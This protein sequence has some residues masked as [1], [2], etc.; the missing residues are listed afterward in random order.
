MK[1]LRRGW[2]QLPTSSRECLSDGV[3]CRQLASV[4]RF[5]S[6]QA[7]QSRPPGGCASSKVELGSKWG[8]GSALPW[9]ANGH[10]AANILSYSKNWAQPASGEHHEKQKGVA[11][12]VPGTGQSV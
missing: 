7:E 2:S 9:I 12:Q 10:F 6:S 1:T 5:R 3:A 4:W 8:W 11:S